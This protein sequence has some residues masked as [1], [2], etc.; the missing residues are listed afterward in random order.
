[1]T[2]HARDRFRVPTKTAEVARAAFPK[3]NV[4]MTMRD[5]L[6]LRYKDSDF[7]DLFVSPQGRPAESPGLLALVTVMQY[8]EGLTDRQ[9][10]EM[11]SARIDWKYALGLELDDCGFHFSVLSTFRERVIGGGAEQRLLDD[12]LARFKELKLVKARGRQRTDSTHVLTAV[13]TVN[14]LE[15]VGETLR[16]AL[17]ALAVAVPDW[18]VE[19]VT[20]DW[21][22]RYGAR[23]EQY[24][25]P[26]K[27]AERTALGETIGADGVHL[28]SRVYVAQDLGWLREIPAIEVLRQVWVQQY[29]VQ[30]GQVKWRKGEDMPASKQLICTPYDTDARYRKKRNTNWTGYAV[31]LSEA[32][33]QDTP[34][35]IT[36]VET[37]P[38]TTGDVELTDNIHQALAD[39]DLLPSEHFV[40]TGY[41]DAEHLVTSRT[42][43]SLDLVGP[44]PLDS[45]WQ[46]KSGQGFAIPCFAIDWETQTVTCPQG[47]ISRSWHERVQ[48]GNPVIQVRFRKPDCAACA[49]RSHCTR[50]KNGARVLTLKPRD[51]HEALQAARERQKTPEFKERYK[52]RAGAEGTISQGVRTFELRRARYIGL[53]KNRLTHIAIAA[54]INLT[55]A[56]LWLTD[57]PKAQTRVSHFR[58][59]APCT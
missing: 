55:R 27:L 35:L 21:F 14:R 54:A 50:S 52:I 31:H 33:D 49:T 5:T 24:R 9:A 8:A 7:A 23:F 26:K 43:H 51:Q 17:E 59:L 53:A 38:A 42:D 22:E 34:N 44:A 20:P 36:H 10:A 30:D 13:R 46:A 58:A 12:M 28:L 18:L 15:C 2:L 1:M 6:D 39:K 45:T 47:K 25:L 48:K 29:Y 19:Q 40:D 41:V 16:A 32:C 11:V 37:T 56:V 3:G 4:Y 57:V